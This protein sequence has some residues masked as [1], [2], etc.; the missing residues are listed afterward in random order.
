MLRFG[1]DFRIVFIHLKNALNYLL[2]M[3][4]QLKSHKDHTLCYL[5]TYNQRG[6]K[7]SGLLFDLNQSMQRKPSL[8]DKDQAP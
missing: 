1:I 6:P 3:V 7:F 2:I 8:P 5:F 4:T